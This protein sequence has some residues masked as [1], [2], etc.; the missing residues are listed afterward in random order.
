[1]TLTLKIGDLIMNTGYRC[2]YP[3][4]KIA[5]VAQSA[6]DMWFGARMMPPVLGMFSL[7]CQRILIS[8]RSPGCKMA[9][10]NCRQPGE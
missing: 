2:A 10:E 1:M 3:S 6:Y 8:S 9:R 4:L 5:I 7:P